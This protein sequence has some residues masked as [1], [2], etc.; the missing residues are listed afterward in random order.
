MTVFP[1]HQ[2]KLRTMIM[3]CTLLLK[4]YAMILNSTV[5]PP[6]DMLSF[7]FL[8]TAGHGARYPT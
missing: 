2:I 3:G 5:C 7:S 4:H 8:L 1:K 6:A